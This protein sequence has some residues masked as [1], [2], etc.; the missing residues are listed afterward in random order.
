MVK[1]YHFDEDDRNIFGC[2]DGQYVDYSEYEKLLSLCEKLYVARW[3]NDC[4][5]YEEEGELACEDCEAENAYD[6][7]K[8]FKEENK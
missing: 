5:V 6:E 2:R 8:K 3:C 1:R 7:Y 4:S